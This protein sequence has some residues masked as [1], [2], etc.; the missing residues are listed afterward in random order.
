MPERPPT[1]DARDRILRAAAAEIHQQGYQAASIASILAE[2]GLTKGALYHHFPSKHALG[3]AVV[4]EVIK[5]GLEE[6]LLSPLRDSEQPLDTLLAYFDKRNA[7]ITE[8]AVRLG[9]PLN[10]LVQEMS[11]LDEAFKSRL[12]A[13]LQTWQQLIAQALRWGQSMGRIRSDTDCDDAA[14]FIVSAWEGCWGAAKNRQSV[15]AYQSCMK[16]LKGYILSLAPATVAPLA[17]EA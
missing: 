9:C 15:A 6:R 1:H 11:P 13:I 12:N 7:Q 10:N 14:L 8:Q 5:S 2:T 3:L 4:D 17:T 16:Q